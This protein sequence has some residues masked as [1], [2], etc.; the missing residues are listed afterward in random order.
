M[1]SQKAQ[2]LFFSLLHSKRLVCTKPCVQHAYGENWQIWLPVS[3]TTAWNDI[4]NRDWKRNVGF[5][6]HQS[7]SSERKTS[8]FLFLL[9][10]SIRS[11]R[12][13][14]SLRVSSLVGESSSDDRT[15]TRTRMSKLFGSERISL[16]TFRAMLSCGLKSWN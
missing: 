14:R 3:S 6:H 13:L 5:W 1:Q 2:T 4:S 8:F 12:I 7:F 16:A 9:T 11:P 10:F 15:F